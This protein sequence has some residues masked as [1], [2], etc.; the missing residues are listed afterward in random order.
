MSFTAIHCDSLR[1]VRFATFAISDSATY[2]DYLRIIIYYI[3]ILT[4]HYY[5]IATIGFSAIAVLQD[6]HPYHLLSISVIWGIS[7]FRSL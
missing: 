1:L 7:L 3:L 2:C 6:S 5:L 4:T